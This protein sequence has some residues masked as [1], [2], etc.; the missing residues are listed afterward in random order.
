MRYTFLLIGI[1]LIGI[2]LVSNYLF[3]EPPLVIK[4]EQKLVVSATTSVPSTTSATRV[5]SLAT[6]ESIVPL[7][8]ACPGAR[9]PNSLEVARTTRFFNKY[10]T[11]LRKRIQEATDT[12]DIKK[13]AAFYHDQLSLELVLAALEIIQHDP[14]NIAVVSGFPK[15]FES[16]NNYYFWN[17]VLDSKGNEI[18]LL[19]YFRIPLANKG[20]LVTL[21]GQQSNLNNYIEQDKVGNWNNLPYDLRKEIYTVSKKVKKDRTAIELKI[22]QVSIANGGRK[23]IEE[24]LLETELNKI[25]PHPMYNLM[26]TIVDSNTYIAEPIIR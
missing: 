3:T 17:Y 25:K 8:Q 23:S 12:D 1:C 10:D 5:E 9:Q 26:P 20:R 7:Y 13:L 11:M 19:L 22:Q 4:K 2:I 16:D 14:D 21:L 24:V 18:P 6:V 15:E